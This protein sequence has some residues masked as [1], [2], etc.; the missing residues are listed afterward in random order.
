M[1]LVLMFLLLL[2]PSALVRCC[3]CC[4]CS[5]SLCS[6]LFSRLRSC[7]LG[8]FFPQD[9]AHVDSPSCVFQS[10]RSR[11][12]RRAVV[13]ID[14]NSV[15]QLARMRKHSCTPWSSWPCVCLQA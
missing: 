11:K 12:V 2:P 9:S 5:A 6:S 1:G 3:C 10:V 13:C 15:T 4:R 14:V 8:R 7:V